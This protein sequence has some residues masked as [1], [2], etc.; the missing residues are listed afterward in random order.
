MNRAH[1]LNDL[2]W[3]CLHGHMPLLDGQETQQASKK[4]KQFGSDFGVNSFVFFAFLLD[5]RFQLNFYTLRFCTYATVLLYF[6]QQ[7]FYPYF[8][9]LISSLGWPFHQFKRF[10]YVFVLTP[11][12]KHLWRWDTNLGITICSCILVS[13]SVIGLPWAVKNRCT[14]FHHCLTCRAPW[15]VQLAPHTISELLV[16]SRQK[17]K[18]VGLKT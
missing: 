5:L 12:Q 3:L 10:H 2:G 8:P 4:R 16:I 1:W 7:C 15:W 14:Q 6:F 9:W 11:W 17:I 13:I 18:A